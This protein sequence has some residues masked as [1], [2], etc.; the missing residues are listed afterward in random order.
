MTIKRVSL[1]AAVLGVLILTLASCKPVP[2]PATYE[3]AD[4]RFQIPGGVD[5]ECG[6]LSVPENRSRSDSPLIKLHIAYIH[7]SNP[8]PAQDPVVILTGGPGVNALDSISYW[9]DLLSEVRANR[10][11]ILFDQR[12]VGYSQPSLNCPEVEQREYQDWTVNLST[13]EFNNNYAAALNTCHDRLTASGVDLSAYNSVENASDVADLRKALG[14]AEWNLYG[15]SY[16]TRLALTI[17]RD[18]PEGIRSVILDSV[19]PPQVSFYETMAADFERSLDLVFARCAADPKCNQAYPNLGND[20]YTVVDQLDAT[21]VSY[22]VFHPSEN[23]KMYTVLLNGDR[24]IST[25]VN[26]LYDSENISVLPRIVKQ[27]MKGITSSFQP[28][29]PGTVFSDD[30]LSEAMYF[31]VNCNDEIPSNSMEILNKVEKSLNPRLVEAIDAQSFFQMCSPRSSYKP[32]SRENK[33]V[34]SD[35]PTLVLSGEFDPVTPPD[36]GRETAE[37]LSRSQFFEFPGFTHDVLGS[38]SDGGLCTTGMVTAFLE[39]STVPVDASCID[40]LY[41]SFA[42]K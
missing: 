36:W 18:H 22:Y 30:S 27:F 35:I 32:P 40:S 41:F 13:A 29:M 16:G 4:C 10:D 5:I 3:K 23:N 17:M 28:F 34:K 9:M 20:F 6:W 14:I 15:R 26:L 19:Y 37:A 11:V 31:S 38:G 2:P 25:V 12:G 21:P 7:S 24:F 39:N 42:T 8:S 33:I 1:A